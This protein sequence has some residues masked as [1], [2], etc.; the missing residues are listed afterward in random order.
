M[1]CSAASRRGRRCPRSTCNATSRCSPGL[2]TPGCPAGASSTCCRASASGRALLG[3]PLRRVILGVDTLHPV[4]EGRIFHWRRDAAAPRSPSTGA[5]SPS[6]SSRPAGARARS[7][8]CTRAGSRCCA[9]GCRASRRVPGARRDRR[10]GRPTTSRSSPLRRRRRDRPDGLHLLVVGDRRT[11]M[12]SPTATSPRSSCW[13]PRSRSR[14]RAPRSPGSPRPWSRPISAAMPATGCCAATST[15]ASPRRSAPCSGS[16]TSGLHPHRRYRAAGADHSAA[17][18]LCRC[19]RLGD[20]EP[21]RRGPEADRRWHPRDLRA[22]DEP[23]RTAA[24]RSMPPS[25]ASPAS[26]R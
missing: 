7:I 18:R 3:L 10:R 5:R 20:P 6:A 15:A 24:A 21:G 9:G 1:L 11:S 13:S 2:R 22:A 16:A 25:D 17:Q 4:L 19:D 26:R 8:I 12:A 23:R 14:S